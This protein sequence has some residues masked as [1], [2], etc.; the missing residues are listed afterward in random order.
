MLSPNSAPSRVSK[1]A[2]RSGDALLM[3]PPGKVLLPPGFDKRLQ[4]YH[5]GLAQDEVEIPLL[6]G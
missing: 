2:A 6:V 4:A 5:G 3:A 1:R